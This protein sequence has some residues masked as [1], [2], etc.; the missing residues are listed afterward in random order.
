MKTVY[1]IDFHKLL[2]AGLR[3]GYSTPETL[4]NRNRCRVGQIALSDGPLSQYG[5]NIFPLTNC[6]TFRF[7]TLFII[8]GNQRDN[9]KYGT[10]FTSSLRHYGMLC[11]GVYRYR[12]TSGTTDASTKRYVITNPPFE[13]T[14]MPSDMVNLIMI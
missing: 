13:F 6:R 7:L 9:G 1:L 11:I 14:L 12:D 3:G 8:L 5:V 2:G 10:L 4:A